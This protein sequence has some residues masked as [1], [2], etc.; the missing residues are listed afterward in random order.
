[1]IHCHRDSGAPHQGVAIWTHD[2]GSGA[3]PAVGAGDFTFV[4]DTRKQ[5]VVSSLCLISQTWS[6][7]GIAFGVG[8]P[9]LVGTHPDYRKRGLVRAQMDVIHAWGATRGHKMQVIGGIP[10]FYR[11]FGYEMGLTLG[12]GRVGFKHQ[13]P[14]LKEGQV[15][16]YRLRP[17]TEADLPFV[18]EVYEQSCK[19]GPL[20]C[21]RD[22]ALLRYELSG[23]TAGS[24]QERVLR[25][26]ETSEGEMVGYLVH[27]CALE[28]GML[29]LMAYE[30][31]PGVSWL[32]VTPSVVRH[33][34]QYADE[35]AAK[36]KQEF[37]AY[38]FWLGAE[39]PVYDV[40]R[41]G[42]PDARPPY[43]WYVR[44][45][46]L[47]GF[48]CHIAPVLERRLSHSPLVGYTG[49]LNIT[50]Y[51]SGVRLIFEHG[52]LQTVEVWETTRDMPGN[53]GFPSL[54][55]L[56]LLCGYRSL[57]ELRHALADCWVGSDEARVLLTSLFPKQ[58]SNVSHVS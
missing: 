49:M 29:P 44:V 11:Q 13:V 18:A 21:V 39:H 17:V 28:G 37:R 10:H 8:M 5:L 6:Y 51:R 50:F 34:A 53:A 7:E 32:A 41:S 35:C 22:M 47:P 40:F 58:P 31:K 2:L 3:H 19:R 4:E 33:I 56:Q 46:D 38:G 43:A 54:T 57:D 20:A 14:K 42:L 23:R 52:R 25:L 12:G 16:P 36:D 26:I 45:T 55:F 9:E 24:V 15:E 27:G 30:L 48:L 1:M